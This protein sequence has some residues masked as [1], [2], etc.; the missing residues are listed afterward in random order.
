MKIITAYNYKPTKGIKLDPVSLTVPDQSFTINEL[1]RKY[2]QGMEVPLKQGEF[3]QGNMD[4]DGPDWDELQRMDFSERYEKLSTIQETIEDLKREISDAN[5]L[6]IDDIEETTTQT[7][8]VQQD[9]LNT[10]PDSV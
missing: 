10:K 1:F 6:S 9:E 2:S 8:K 4:I 7:E 5:Q 3:L